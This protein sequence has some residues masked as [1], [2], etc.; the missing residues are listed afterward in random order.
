MICC[1][2]TDQPVTDYASATACDTDAFAVFFRSM[3]DSGIL[4]PPSQYEAWF[5]STAHD[6]SLID[7]TLEAAIDAFKAVAEHRSQQ[8]SS[9]SAEPE[10]PA[11]AAQAAS[12]LR[13]GKNED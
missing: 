6:A 5:P 4:L 7:Q 12:T 2:F 13:E 9:T 11:P 1:F 10:T 3:L 8:A